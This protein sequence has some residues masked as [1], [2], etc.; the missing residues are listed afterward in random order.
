MGNEVST[1][2][3]PSAVVVDAASEATGAGRSVGTVGFAQAAG[4]GV[5]SGDELVEQ[6]EVAA[7]KASPEP[8]TRIVRSARM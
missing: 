8:S 6:P 7:T 4:V 1:A 3:P 2:G 5:G